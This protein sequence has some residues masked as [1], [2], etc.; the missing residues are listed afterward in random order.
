MFGPITT[1]ILPDYN[2]LFSLVFTKST[3]NMKTVKLLWKQLNFWQKSIAS[4]QQSNNF[5]VII[6]NFSA[7]DDF[8]SWKETQLL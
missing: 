7:A 2:F 8:N 6:Y 3:K 1:L 5:F 4:K